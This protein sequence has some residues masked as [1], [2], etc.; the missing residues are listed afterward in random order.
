MCQDTDKESNCILKDKWI[1]YI[2]NACFKSIFAPDRAY[3]LA[4]AH[5]HFIAWHLNDLY[6]QPLFYILFAFL[7]K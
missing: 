7:K 2:C 4:Y 1:F 3:R 6:I 5:S